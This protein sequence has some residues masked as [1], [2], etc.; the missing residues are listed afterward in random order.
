VGKVT[1]LLGRAGVGKSTRIAQNIARQLEQAPIGP[2][3]YWVVPNDASFS[4]EKLLTHHV[5][6]TLRTEVL[7][8]HRLAERANQG[9]GVVQ[10][11]RVN[12]AGKRLLLAK[13]YQ[14]LAGNLSVLG[15]VQ[16]TVGFLDAILGVFDEL[17][18]HQVSI[19]QMESL[20]ETAAA[21]VM[22]V[23]NR[24]AVFAG[25]SLIGKLRD[26]CLLYVEWKNELVRHELFDT[27]ELMSV[28]TPHLDQW[29]S[30]HEATIYIDGFVDLSPQERAFVLA[31]MDGAHE[32][33]VSLSIDPGWLS[34]AVITAPHG[35]MAGLSLGLEESI[36]LVQLLESLPNS[37]AVYAPQ[38]VRLF[39]Q[40]KSGC[41]RR[42]IEWSVETQDGTSGTRFDEAVDLSVLERNLY[43]SVAAAAE[44]QTRADNI[45]VFAAVNARVESYGVAREI[46][47]LVQHHG[48][49]YGDIVVVV[50]SLQDYESY[51]LE[52]FEAFQIPGYVDS[53]P[54]L[55][56][57]PFARFVLASLQLVEED[58]S[59]ESVL[60][61]L[62]TDFCGIPRDEVDWLETY[63]LKYE[64]DHVRYWKQ[65]QPWEFAERARDDVTSVTQAANEDERAEGLRQKVVEIYMPFYEALSSYHLNTK[66]I[67]EALWH[68]FECVGAKRLMASWMVDADAGRTPMEASLHEQAWQRVMGMLNDFYE[69]ASD[70]QMPRSFLFSVLQNEM[71]QQTLST[72]PAGLNEVTVTEGHRARGW[73]AEVV[74]VMGAIDG[75]LPRKVRASGILRDEEREQFM[76]L[77][78]TRL[79]NT[80][81]ELQ[82]C[83]RMTVYS[84][85]T[86]AKRRLIL[87]YPLAT[88]DGKEIRPSLMLTRI[89][90]LF[91][92]GTLSEQVWRDPM[93]E[94]WN[95]Q[96]A[97]T[98]PSSR[99]ALRMLV[100][101]LG[102][103]AN[104]GSLPPIARTIV[105]DY[106]ASAEKRLLL[107]RA[108][109]GL[110]HNATAKPIPRDLA[111]ALYGEP[112]VVNVHQLEAFAA[113]PYQHFVRYGLAVKEQQGMDIGATAKGMLKHD[114]L[115][116][117]VEKHMKD[118]AAWREMT[119][120]DAIRSVHEVYEDVMSR[121][122]ASVWSKKPSRL[123]QAAGVLRELEFA[124][125]VLTRHVK[126][127][128]FEPKAVELTFGGAA[129]EGLPGFE[130]LLDNGAKVVLRGRIDRVDF[131]TDGERHAFRIVDYK[132]SQLRLD[133]TKVA[134][135]LRLQLPVYA[136]VIA[137]YSERIHG[138]ASEP[139][140]MLY[141]PIVHKVKL[142]TVPTDEAKAREEFFKNMRASG[143]FVNDTTLVGWMDARL[144]DGSNTSD[145]FSKIY[146]K[147]GSVAEY[148][149]V[150]DA[151]DWK[152]LIGRAL[153][154]VKEIGERIFNGDISISPYK[155]SPDDDACKWCRLSN[156]CHFEKRYDGRAFRRLEKVQKE[157]IGSLWKRYE[158][159]VENRD[160][161]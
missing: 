5:G 155:L 44:R 33:V 142:Y 8:L 48:V 15:R 6:T 119:D 110:N 17:I 18:R 31:L 80:T 45:K 106:L 93:Q 115:L 78:G 126:F 151:G 116:G 105:R 66:T 24:R 57:H 124:A 134:H 109:Q 62:K 131:A 98:L 13:A 100:S 102:A 122:R 38:T 34:D 46:H 37:D 141:I 154:H 55:S 72:I 145:L 118:V 156:I 75:A 94:V 125:V 129:S 19:S 74:F 59:T 144:T 70:E 64:I 103:G 69:T 50:P 51:L 148:A 71:E 153:A 132:S 147:N 81:E 4:T 28:L 88:S 79:G 27:S 43:G 63:L 137:R 40:L 52:S 160:R 86:R 76:W 133:L 121:P 16:P 99:Y 41:N 117:F 7:T 20:L 139:A 101:A 25:T 65:A 128:R 149:P 92:R 89:R 2:P 123:E 73:D 12:S 1:F 130:V 10:T 150:L 112:L 56:T 95:V 84:I 49:S 143:M 22:E 54:A 58:F 82:L 114:V 67:A 157:D 77:F 97:G 30:L 35:G 9:M 140:G 146:N 161:P 107:L 53:F 11:Q 47:N 136:A 104:P 29:S 108:L 85:L 113:C 158:K 83:E 42:G 23:E 3:I 32:S 90:S 120:D 111:K 87:S 60:R 91:Q 96:A 61:V 127:G 39:Q 26:L 14:R 68:L 152:L 36:H 159:E 135:G 21:S 138:M